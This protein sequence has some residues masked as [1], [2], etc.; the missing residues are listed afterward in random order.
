MGTTGWIILG[1]IVLLGLGWVATYNRLVSLRQRCRQAF[2]DIDVQLK[3]RH[4]RFDVP[5]RME[6]FFID[7]P[8]SERISGFFSTHP[9]VEARIDALQRYAGAEIATPASPRG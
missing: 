7:N 2:A 3:Q 5:S 9:S 1:L 8:V 4:D 6:A